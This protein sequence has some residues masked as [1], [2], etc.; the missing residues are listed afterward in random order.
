MKTEQQYF[1]EAISLQEYMDKMES[2]KDNSFGIYDQFQ[3]PQDDEFIELLREKSPHIL[4]I[5]EDWCGDAMMN[6][7]IL[8]RITEAAGIE[9]RVVYRDQNLEL[10]D[11]YLTNGG[12]SIPVYLLLNNNGDVIGKWGPRAPKIQEYVLE[13]RKDFPA[14]DDPTF[15]AKQKEFIEHMTSAYISKPEY[16]LW[17][18][19]DVRKEFTAALQKQ[20]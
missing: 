10:M 16:W 11:Q 5:T 6:N 4:G 3:V 14:S 8:R 9:L 1:E 13:L 17:V 20:S 19:E 2:H 7:P 15:K 18:Y 12:R